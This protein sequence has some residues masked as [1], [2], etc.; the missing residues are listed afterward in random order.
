MVSNLAISA[1]LVMLFLL[2][3]TLTLGIVSGI[4]LRFHHKIAGAVIGC[5]AL[6]CFGLTAWVAAAIWLS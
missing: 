5:L 1:V 6:I 4:L 2:G 3:V